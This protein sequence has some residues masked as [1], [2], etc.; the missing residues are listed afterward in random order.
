M[1]KVVYKNRK[2]H[3]CVIHDTLTS[4][5]VLCRDEC[6]LTVSVH[7]Y[8]CVHTHNPPDL[9]LSWCFNDSTVLK[10]YLLTFLW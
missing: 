3:G 6:T 4:P 8:T 7:T 1:K 2:K 5:L 9:L 10:F